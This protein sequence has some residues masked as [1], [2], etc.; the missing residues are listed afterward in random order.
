MDDTDDT[1]TGERKT[2]ARGAAPARGAT[3]SG[4]AT[5]KRRDRIDFRVSEAERDALEA[6]AERVALSLGSY[7]RA[8]TLAAP[9]TRAQRRPTIEREL[10]AKAVAML[11]RAI[12]SLHQIAKHLNFGDVEY[13]A[14]IPAA[15]AE[16]RAAIAA[17]MAAAG[18]TPRVVK[19]REDAA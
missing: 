1:G 5:R 3:R 9:Q 17:T 6:A 18:R 13:A 4:S 7:I 10:M 12:G 14:D 19:D 11:G 16:A 15:V 2:P 8:C